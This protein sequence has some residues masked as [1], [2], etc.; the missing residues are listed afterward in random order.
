MDVI[1]AGKFFLDL[2]TFCF[3]H[4]RTNG[5]VSDLK[6]GLNALRHWTAYYCFENIL[7]VMETTYGF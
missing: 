3:W 4:K 5:E 2:H 6:R 7:E 1:S